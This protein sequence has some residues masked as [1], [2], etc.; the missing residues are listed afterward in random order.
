L[1]AG[2]TPRAAAFFTALGFAGTVRAMPVAPL[3]TD[4]LTTQVAQGV[5]SFI[6]DQRADCSRRMG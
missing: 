6:A 3:A 1:K 5:A 2:G 4:G